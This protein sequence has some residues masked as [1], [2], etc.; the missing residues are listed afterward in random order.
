MGYLEKSHQRQGLC[1]SW[2]YVP[3]T[4][5]ILYLYY[6]RRID[7]IRICYK[8]CKALRLPPLS[9]RHRSG[10]SKAPQRKKNRVRNAS[11]PARERLEPRR[12]H[13]FAAWLSYQI[14]IKVAHQEW[15]LARQHKQRLKNLRTQ[16]GRCNSVFVLLLA[17]MN[18]NSQN[19]RVDATTNNEPRQAA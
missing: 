9:R 1:K 17:P 2:Y 10:A 7:F 15:R 3:Y 16:L 11:S 8:R 5:I 19:T 14:I 18:M 13:S 12:S 6:L 4:Y